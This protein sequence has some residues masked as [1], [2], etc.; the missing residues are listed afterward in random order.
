MKT[1]LIRS[2]LLASTICAS[3]LMVAAPA[4]SQTK[5]AAAAEAAAD[6]GEIIVTGSL[7]K[8]AN[9][10]ASAPVNVTTSEEIKLRQTNV[11]EEL[12]R[13]IP[14]A[15][16]SIGSSVNNG[17]NGASYVDLRGLGSNRNIV[18]L[19][20]NRITPSNTVGRTD[21]NNIP[22]ALVERVDVLTGGA[23]TTYGADAISGVV[24]FITKKDFS[25][26]DVSF[27]KEITQ[28]GDGS[29]SHVDLTL[30]ANFDDG[31]G[32]VVLSLGYQTADPV[33]QGD[34]K[35]S[36]TQYSS[37]TGKA[38]G[39]DVTVPAEFFLANSGDQVQIDPA[40]GALVPVYQQFNF[41]PYNVFRTPFERY[42]MYGSG[43]YEINDSVE[44]YGRGLFSKNTVN[45]IVAPSG[46]FDEVLTVPVSNPYLPLI[47]RNQFCADAGISP[48]ACSLAAAATSPTDINYKTLDVE[49]LRRTPDVGPRISN[50][51]TTVF[52]FRAGA[53]GKVNDHINWDV[54]T[55]YGESTNLQTIKNYVLL[56]RVQQAVLAT[57]PTSCL[58]TSGGCVPLNIFG[59]AGSITPAQAAFLTANSTTQNSTSLLQARALVNGDLGFSSPGAADAVGFAVGGEYRKY[60]ASQGADLLAKTAGE[61]GGAGGAAPDINGGYHVY[62]AFGELIV[63]L[64]QDKP[65]FNSL[66]VEGGL[67][68][69]AYSVDAPG[70]P[71]FNTTTYKGGASWEPVSGLKFRGNYQHAVRAPN[72][73]ELFAPV[74][75]GLTN[76]T[77]EPCVGAAALTNANLAAVC[78]AQGAPPSTI[79]KINNPNSGQANSYGGGNPNVGPETSNSYTIGTVF[80]PSFVPRLAISVDYYNIKVQGAITVPTPGDVIN[81]CFGNLTAAS[82]TSLACTSIRR[83]PTT[84]QLS[85]SPA[86]TRGLPQPLSNLGRLA[87]DGI[88]LT[89][90]Y[91]YDLGPAKLGLNFSGNWTAHSKF[92]ATPS[93]INRECVGYYSTNCASIQPRFSWNQRTTLGFDVVDISLLW[94]HLS[95]AKFEPRVGTR[96]AGT[97]K[98]GDL[99]GT[100]V[101]FNK[102]RAYEYFDL[103]G[104]VQVVKN[105][106]MT[107]TVSNL[108]NVLPPVLGNTIGSTLYNSG[109]TY[110][111][112]YDALGRRF[113]VGVD[114]TF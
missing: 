106:S 49:T 38:A 65:F 93:G 71:K 13:A 95:S 84:G 114:V 97:L 12:L 16:P 76:L 29:Y 79:G 78:L 105:V 46:V 90:N 60:K 21:L 69:S 30:G 62:E 102:I 9:L 101:D 42:N 98:G 104:R 24:N 37:T 48:T 39:S 44:V 72:I 11:A 36:N 110:P 89:V 53:R 63:P 99:N 54:N 31:R 15:V 103:A 43:R 5:T 111:S 77:T 23:S 66:T 109:N 74:T 91:N 17:N 34:R 58:T 50:Y 81:A 45:T 35:F 70:N 41:N 4:F 52:D 80:Q 82:A 28:S 64:L 87:T 86:T 8:N 14:G 47:A 1:N 75:T 2:R 26:V 94:R 73:N 3:A 32:N 68:Y 18:L 108:F 56:S 85:G 67:R 7:I 83:N 33:Y 57:N 19:D 100:T 107:L 6:T 59:G 40:T 88:D 22:L 112:S 55:S 20:G 96:F 113:A 51:V 25:G 27:G 92:Q 10:T 61:L